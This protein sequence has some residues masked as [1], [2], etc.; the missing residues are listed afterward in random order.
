AAIRQPPPRSGLIEGA[1]TLAALGVMTGVSISLPEESWKTV[2]PVALLFPMLLWVAARCR[3][4]FAAAA[5][6]L[7]SMSV[8]STAVFG[9]GHFGDRSLPFGDL[10]VQAQAT[11]LF[12]A[13]GA[14][15]LAALFAERKES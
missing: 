13:L 14:Y 3:P 5:A 8:V 12:V 1:T 15:V 6:F 11:I 7:V 2:A 10:I 4:V 9:V